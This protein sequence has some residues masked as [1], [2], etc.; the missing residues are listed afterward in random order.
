[1]GLI[2]RL[3]FV[4]LALGVT[5]CQPS[6]TLFA[7]PDPAVINSLYLNPHDIT[8]SQARRAARSPAGPPQRVAGCMHLIRLELIE[9]GCSHSPQTRHLSDRSF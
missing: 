6:F 9:M 4:L 7:T 5:A 8:A 2:K 3:F 1:M